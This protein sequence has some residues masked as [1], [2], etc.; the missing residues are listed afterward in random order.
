MLWHFLRYIMAF[1]GPTFYKRI[2]AKND[3]YL[4]NA[5]GPV[6]LALNH[7]NA[8]TD[9]S[10][11]VCVS[12]PV[13][14][15]YLARGDAFKPGLISVLLESI[16]I[17]PI[18][19]IQDGG[20]E[21]LK[22]NDESYKRANELLKRK[23]AKVMI[24]AEGLC[25]QER[26]L[27]PLK[28][29]VARF[30]FGAQ[31]YLGNDE[32]IV[33]PVG[34]NYSNPNKFRSTLFYNFG[35]PIKVSDFKTLY[36]ENPPKAYTQFLQTLEPKMRALI[37][38]I[39]DKRFDAVVGHFEKL[40]KKDWLKE[41]G[42]SYK[43]LEQDYTVSKQIV[44]LVN[45]VTEKEPER[46]LQ[47]QDKADVYLKALKANKLRDWLLNPKQNKKVTPTNTN[48][49]LLIMVLGFPLYGLALLTS[50]L[51]YFLTV[52]LTKKIVKKNVE[53]YSSF[54]LST[55]MFIF[56]INYILIFLITWHFSPNIGWA[57]VITTLTM[58]IAWYGLHFYYFKLKTFGMWRYLKHQTKFEE[59]IVKRRELVK[60]MESLRQQYGSF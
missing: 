5:K 42:W 32:L 10:V 37:M 23:N 24:Y 29:G 31:D 4:Q 20:K 8:F 14:T 49:R 35:E 34:L 40:C 36:Q 46:L 26:R 56:L 13:R 22:K 6:I 17:L 41:Q 21:G 11:F 18:F 52:R 51:P 59:L 43:N 9:P 12:Y 50:Y 19:R 48:L 27:R 54:A 15:Y 53:F 16:G 7:P 39:N 47:L 55:G 2:Q 28:K 25:I 30:T 44:E 38:H 57:L 60:E 3:H 33:I 45:S 58:L 1:A